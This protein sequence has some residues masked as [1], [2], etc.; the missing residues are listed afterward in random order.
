MTNDQ[1]LMTIL[2]TGGAGFIGSHLCEKLLALGHDVICIDNF[3]DYYDPKIKR[4]NIKNCLNN[5]NFKLHE[6]DIRNISKITEIFHNTGLKTKDKRPMIVVHLAA[7]AGVRPSL[8]D[9]ELY[10]DVNLNGTK[11]L[12]DA[13]V[14]TDV[15]KFIFASSS[16]VYGNN[17]KVPFAE[18]DPLENII[19]PYASTKK[20]GEALCLKYHKEHDLPMI[21]LR[22]FTVYGPRQRPEMAIHK[23]TRLI[24]GNKEIPMYGAGDTARDY[25]YIDDILSGILSSLEKDLSYEIINLGESQVIKLKDLIKTIEQKLQKKAHIKQLPEQTGD[26]RQTYAD[27]TKA[28]KLLGY[29][30]QTKID[31][32]I[33]KF[34]SWYKKEKH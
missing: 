27:I 17:T 21:C 30:P 13:S 2:V 28:K 7:R 12:L 32:G 8:Q 9:P 31:K 3:N 24:D 4:N 29:D 19:S 16:S 5:K 15:K 34:I 1:R 26:V 6:V 20:E 22:F 18:S 25:T 33:A 11:N 10:K 14:K 23:F